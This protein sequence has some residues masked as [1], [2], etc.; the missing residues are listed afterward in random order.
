M[1]TTGG[2]ASLIKR[3]IEKARQNAGNLS[4]T[5]PRI[6]DGGEHM[7]DQNAGEL[8]FQKHQS[9]VQE[10]LDRVSPQTGLLSATELT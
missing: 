5:P 4:G 2:S 7:T 9:Q 6:P 8:Q 3:R 10:L 1:L